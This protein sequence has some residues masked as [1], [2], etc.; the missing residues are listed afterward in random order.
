M[1]C[2]HCQKRPAVTYMK[3]VINGKA[4]ELALCAECAAEQGFSSAF[5][6]NPG[7]FWGSLFAEPAK[8]VREDT[9]RCPDCGSSFRD[10]AQRGRPVC[11]TCY[12]TFYE[13]LLPS[14]QRIHGK[15]QHTG[16][17]AEHAGESARTEHALKQLREQ[18]EVCV[19]NQEYEKCAQLRDRIRELEGK[20][21]PS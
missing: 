21:D 9:E 11:P 17:V 18:L 13:R 15:T 10:V 1:L 5:G 20:G 16:K 2:S 14:V 19:A 7:D 3:Q 6:F 12:V 4:M 8:R